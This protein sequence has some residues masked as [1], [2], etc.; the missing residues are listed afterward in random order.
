MAQSNKR[1]GLI[2]AHYGVAVDV[3]YQDSDEVEMVRVKRNSG[4]VVGDDVTVFEDILT[5]QERR[6]ELARLDTRGKL[7][8]V[9]ANLDVLGIVVSCEPLPPPNFID[10]A[11]VAARAAKLNPILILNKRDLECFPQYRD[12]MMDIYQKS[13]PIFRTSATEL[14]GLEELSSYF[15]EG[16]RGIFVG[17]SGVGK[18]SILNGLLPKIELAT[19]AISENKKRGRHTTTV[20][21]LHSLKDGGE[22]IDS[23]GFSDFGLV[24]ITATELAHF[25]PGFE[26]ATNQYCQFLD[27]LHRTEP[28]CLVKDDLTENIIPQERYSSYLQLLAEVESVASEPR[29]RERRH[30][31]KK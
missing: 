18:S 5:R 30:R 15:K 22:L 13:L 27:C 25:F 29:F 19:G 12:E 28:G 8:T 17:P 4:H 16:H 10:R 7:H 31:R 11:I 21:T 6:T 2:I 9:S 14:H 20:S 23:P 24:D 26:H 1:K 3:R